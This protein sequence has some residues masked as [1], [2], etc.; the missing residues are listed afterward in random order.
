MP[1]SSLHSCKPSSTTYYK[2]VPDSWIVTDRLNGID[3]P[4]WGGSR[5]QALLTAADY[6][7][8]PIH[9]LAIRRIDQW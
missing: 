6:L 7:N 9:T 2:L 3:Y 8:K 1:D 5:R 4:N